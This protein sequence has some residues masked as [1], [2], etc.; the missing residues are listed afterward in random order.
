MVRF[1]RYIILI[2]LL[3]AVAGIFLSHAQ[4]FTSASGIVKDSITGEPLPF[5]SVYFDGSTIGAMTDDNGTFTLQNNQGYTKLAAASLGYDT[6]FIDLKPGK[7]NDNLEVLLK[8]TAFEIS[9]V[10]VKPKREKYTRKDNPAVELIKKV[11]AHKND[12]RIEAKPEYQTEVYEKLSLSLDNFNPNLDKNK[13]LKK[14]KFIKNYLD[15]SEF[16]GKPILTVSVRENLSDFYYRKSPKAEKTIVRAKRMQGI[17]KTLDDGGGITSNLEEIFKSIN[18][19]DNNIP[20]LLNRFVSPLSSTL[21]TTYYHYYIMDTLDVG[22]DK[23]VD[24]AFVPANSESYGFT[25]RLYITLDGNY[26]VKKVLL[27]TPANINLNWVDK[28]RIEQEFKQMPDSTWVLDQEN[29]FVNF[30]VVKGTQQLYA[31][32]LRN[33]DNYNFNVQNADSVFGLLGALHVLPEATAQPDTFWTHNRPIPLKEKEDAL[34]DLLGQLRKVPAFNAIIKTAEILITGYIPTAN[35]KKVTKFDFGPMNTTFSANHLEG[36]RM[37]VG[38]MT[39][40]NLNPYWF[41]SGYLAYGT[42][43]RKIKYNLKLTHSFTKK[44]YHEGENP[45]NNLSFIQEYD[46]YTPGQDF[47]FTSKDNIFVAW[48]V[49][50]PVTKMQYIRKS[51]LQYEKEWLNGLTWKSWIMNQNNEAAGTL[52]YIK[53]DESGNL[54]HIKDFTTSEIGTQLRFAPG[55]RAY[56]GRSGKE[57]VFNLSKDAPVFKLSHQLGIKGVL[58]GDYNYNHTEIS[59]EKRIWLSSFGHIDAQIKAGKVWDKVPFPLLILPNTNQSITIQPEAFHMMNALEFVT[60]QYVSFNATYYLKG[61]ILNRIPGIKWLRLREVLSF[62]MIYGGLTDKNNPTL[63]PGLFLLPDGTQP[64]GSTPY[65]EC[66]VGLENIF[67]ILRIDYYRRLTYL[68]HPDIK[69]GGIRIALRFTF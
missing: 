35:D 25:G 18:I 58:G 24:L 57:S 33:Y 53:R 16:N 23:C 26:A 28:L 17:D 14:F 5:V 68:D 42:N 4:S 56:N 66:S 46:V 64:L 38:G 2:A 67:K 54:Y 55:E 44:E 47:L 63:T 59:A 20:I 8:P 49:G 10:V 43:D 36:F 39:T 19:F 51:V 65:M 6:K 52:Q 34:K 61:W 12:N 32:Q 7:K 37:R 29:T 15:T 27:N 69:K 30:Y 9:E 45:V 48:K 40:A 13:F 21:A 50:E 3:Q 1:I 60:D 62:N 41:A 22:G 31:H 11:I